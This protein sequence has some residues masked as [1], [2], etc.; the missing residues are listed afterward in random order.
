M[1]VT[2]SSDATIAVPHHDRTWLVVLAGG[3]AVWLL[4][5]A[6]TWITRDNILVPTVILVGSFLVP[7]T[8]LVWALGLR[9]AD[10]LTAHVIFLG[11][12]A[13]GTLG[14]LA[15]A[16]VE[17][18]VVPHR[19]GTFLAVGLIEEGS[20]A[21]VL[22]AVA[23]QVR[24]RGPRDGMVLGAIVG[25]GFAAFESSGYA[26]ST[27][28]DHI[29]DHPVYNILQTE[30]S[31]AILA[32]F[33]HILWT[34]LV[35]GA[36]FAGVSAAGR[37]RLTSQLVGTFLGVVAL[38]ALWDAST[39]Y[40]IVITRGLVGEEWSYSWPNVAAWVGLPTK[41]DVALFNVVYDGL[42]V[43]NAVIGTSWVV[44]RY[45]KYTRGLERGDLHVV[46]LV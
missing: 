2:S 3:A 16:M 42:L 34:S 36:L 30:F 17:T 10:R 19:N 28:I 40:A 37:F 9:R 26:F 22:L 45:R 32:P 43:V 33:G 15:S 18:Y 11:F 29:D 12:L 27:I 38:H 21:L 6:I 31:R 4:A 8:V 5:S 41:G 39:G 14:V 1:S 7:V 25:A 35:G 44:H 20:K 46:E 13:G 24:A 23:H